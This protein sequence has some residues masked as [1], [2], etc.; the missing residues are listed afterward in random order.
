[1]R[2]LKLILLLVGFAA[3]AQQKSL[4]DILDF[5]NSK[6]LGYGITTNSNSGLIG[7]LI[8]RSST[9]KTIEKNKAVHRY[10]AI[11]LV[12][13]KHPRERNVSGLSAGRYTRFKTN[14][15]FAVRPE[16]GKEI[17]LFSKNGDN[18]LGLSGIFAVGPTLGIEKPYYI[19]YSKS[20]KEQ[21]QTV[22]YNPDIHTN[23]NQILGSGNIW[24]GFFKGAR[25]NPG[26]H[27]KIAANFDFNSFEDKVSGIEIGS[28]IEAFAR[29]P[30]ILASKIVDNPRV[31]ASV[32][33]TLYFG[34]KKL[35][36]T[37]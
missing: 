28:V 34:N 14:Y 8:L 16:Y 7:G 36:N 13:V 27:V 6:S 17:Y 23:E 11:E 15:L 18:S 9:F 19:K 3:Q 26:A 32:Y 4:S 21:P 5:E 31:F 2:Y 1:V 12:N 29:K 37:K 10:M 33:L 22:P 35:L 25:I 20:Q 30:E 24:Q